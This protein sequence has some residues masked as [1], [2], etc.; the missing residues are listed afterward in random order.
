MRWIVLANTV[1]IATFSLAG[2]NRKVQADASDGAPPP[3]HVEH[4]Q[5]STGFRPEHPERFALVNVREHK[6]APELKVTGS[7]APDISRNIPVI[8]LATG[9]VVEVDARVGDVVRKGQLMLKVQ[10]PDLA[11]AFS[12][13]RQAVADEKLARA[14]LERSRDLFDRGAVARKDLE[15]AEDA[16]DKAKTTM[17]TAAQQLRLLGVNDFEHPGSIVNIYAPASGVVTDQQVSAAGGTQ[18]LASPNAFTISDLSHVWIICDV[19]EN[20]LSLVHVGEY[21]DVRLNAYPGKT[22]KARVS[23]VGAILDP[24]LRTAKV[25]LELDNPGLMRIGMFVTATFH[26]DQMEKHGMIP[27]SA[28]LHLH[29]RDWV[30]VPGPGGMFHR[31]EVTAGEMLPGN[32][33]DVQ[34]IGP[35]QQVVENA[36]VLQETVEQ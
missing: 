27:T 36:L 29:D 3:A 35:G 18:G 22:F 13:Y 2:C 20:D 4:E 28:I 34:G 30:Y 12:N 26:S 11:S 15:F 33:Q 32:M 1:L 5:D 21:A 9:R 10:S 7:V 24:N 8:S 25:R 17:E 23:N 16:E 19:Y 14:Q 6:V 31:V